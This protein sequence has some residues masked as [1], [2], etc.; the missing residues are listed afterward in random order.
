MQR[1]RIIREMG[2]SPIDRDDFYDSQARGRP[3]R[4]HKALARCLGVSD[5]GMLTRGA[6][7]RNATQRCATR[8]ELRLRN[9]VR[10]RRISK[11]PLAGGKGAAR[12]FVLAAVVRRRFAFSVGVHSL[13]GRSP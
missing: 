5:Y 6:A 8:G 12:G 1:G 10:R 7:A 13:S 2:F 3:P 11:C 9:P 4:D